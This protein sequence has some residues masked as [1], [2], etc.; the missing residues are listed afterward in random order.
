[1]L[2]GARYGASRGEDAPSP[3]PSPALAHSAGRLS[4]AASQVSA[5]TNVAAARVTPLLL[6][7]P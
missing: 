6:E 1:M 4:S 7:S 3:F 5:E 2:G